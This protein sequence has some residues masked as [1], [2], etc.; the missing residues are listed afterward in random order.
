MPGAGKANFDSF[1]AA[2]IALA[3]SFSCFTTR[4]S[5]VP[6]KKIECGFGYIII[7]PHIPHILST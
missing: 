5:I 6:L 4:R 1:E 3:V 2:G 7:R